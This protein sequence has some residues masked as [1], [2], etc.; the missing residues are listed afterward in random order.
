MS[1]RESREAIVREHMESENRHEFDVTMGTFHHPR[2]EIVATGD[3]HDGEEAVRQYFADTRRA[4]PDQRNELLELQRAG[5]SRLRKVSSVS[6]VPVWEQFL[7][8]R[9]G[10]E[11]NPSPPEV[12][13]RMA[14]LWDAIRE[15]TERGGA[16]VSIPVAKAPVAPGGGDHEPRVPIATGLA[17]TVGS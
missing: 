5:A 16:V 4:F 7:N 9:A 14:R 15:S 17:G 10:R 11:V 12:G 2:Y 6:P 1:V 8:V 13:L 3:V